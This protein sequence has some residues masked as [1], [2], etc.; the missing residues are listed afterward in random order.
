MFEPL[1][2]AFRPKRKLSVVEQR[3]AARARVTPVAVS[4]TA[5]SK[6]ARE[7]DATMSLR[8]QRNLRIKK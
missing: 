4:K 2:L 7:E 1:T 5:V 3:V 6:R 8:S